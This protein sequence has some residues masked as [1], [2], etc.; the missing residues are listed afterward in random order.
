MLNQLT[1]LH[2]AMAMTKSDA[3]T[4]LVQAAMKL[5]YRNGFATTSL[6]DIAREARVPVGNI[7]YYFKSKN[8]LGRAVV[9]ERLSELQLMQNEWDE[10]GSPKE[11]LCAY[12]NYVRETRRDIAVSGCSTGTLCGELHKSEAGVAMN[13]ASL[14]AVQLKWVERQFR[15]LDGGKEARARALHFLSALQGVSVIS[16]SFGASDLVAMEA[17]RLKK[18][19][20]SL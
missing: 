6:A 1:D 8:D 11:R 19:I 18:W 4:R 17:A 15:L 13:A 12:L 7:Y 5:T 10:A 2:T 16:H 14:L 9:D 20:R 3:S